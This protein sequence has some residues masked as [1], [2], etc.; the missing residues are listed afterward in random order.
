MSKV[1]DGESQGSVG[2]LQHTH[3]HIADDAKRKGADDGAAEHDD[4]REIHMV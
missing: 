1:Y 3:K 4:D 2:V